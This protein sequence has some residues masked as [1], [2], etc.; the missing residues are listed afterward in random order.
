M[1]VHTH[2]TS[3]KSSA[4]LRVYLGAGGREVMRVRC[5]SLVI[6]GLWSWECW[7]VEF[8]EAM[9]E[10]HWGCWEVES[11]GFVSVDVTGFHSYVIFTYIKLCRK[12]WKLITVLQTVHIPIINKLE[13]GSN[14]K[15]W[16]N[17][18]TRH[19]VQ[20]W[21]LPHTM[22]T[23]AGFRWSKPQTTTLI[24]PHYSQ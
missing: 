13:T 23:G 8:S 21:S 22:Y 10:C 11:G 18:I 7:E 16:T 3:Q 5:S 12:T 1:S 15:R 20:S 2:N 6:R 19:A 14:V 17:H 24:F 9:F 4:Q